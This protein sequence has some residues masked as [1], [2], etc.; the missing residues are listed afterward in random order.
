MATTTTKLV[1]EFTTFTVLE[2]IKQ[3][4]QVHGLAWAVK[5]AKKQGI[6]F[7]TVYYC[8]FGKYPNR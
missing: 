3:N 7:D 1:Q 8:F 2:K 4:A 6:N 5:Q